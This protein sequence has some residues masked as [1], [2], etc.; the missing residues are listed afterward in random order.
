MR[1]EEESLFVRTYLGEE[2]ESGC[3]LDEDL[4]PC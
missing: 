1:T 4:M 2:N 3:M